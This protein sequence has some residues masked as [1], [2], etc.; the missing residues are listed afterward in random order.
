MKLKKIIF[1]F[2]IIILMLQS[3]AEIVC[4]ATE[5]E[6]QRVILNDFSEIEKNIEPI[7]EENENLLNIYSEA[8][9]LIEAKTG[10]ILYDKDIY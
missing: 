3:L 2:A 5:D 9:I 10:K 4:N 8:A 7:K 1:S 6:S